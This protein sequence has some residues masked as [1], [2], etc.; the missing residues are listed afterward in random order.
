M[1]E[2]I[3]IRTI[4]LR[5]SALSLLLLLILVATLTV[6]TLN[7]V[8][9]TLLYFVSAGDT[10]FSLRGVARNLPKANAD[11]HLKESLQALID[12]PIES[13]E[14]RGLSTALEPDTQI[15]SLRLLGSEVEVNLSD[16]FIEG[17]G[18]ATMQGRL[19]QVFYTLTQP[20]SVSSVRLLVEGVPITYLGG[21]GILVDNPWFRAEHGTLPTW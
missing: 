17:G 10:S 6:R 15:L 4:V 9:N 12:G 3:N 20:T 18:S 11:T 5:V 14:A 8:P 7:R 1:R 19:N 13:E 16:E 21:E 2:P